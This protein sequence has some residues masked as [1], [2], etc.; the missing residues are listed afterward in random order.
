MAENRG[1]SFGLKTVNSPTKLLIWRPLAEL[2]Q[3]NPTQIDPKCNINTPVLRSYGG[4]NFFIDKEVFIDKQEDVVSGV[5]DLSSSCHLHQQQQR[6]SQSFWEVG[7]SAARTTVRFH[8]LLICES[9]LAR[10]LTRPYQAVAQYDPLKE[11]PVV[12]EQIIKQQP[13]D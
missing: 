13:V 8:R 4:H 9:T 12:T 3:N 2:T 11:F 6:L 10:V 1:F 5:S 7:Q